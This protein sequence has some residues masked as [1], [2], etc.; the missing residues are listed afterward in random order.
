MT[1]SVMK[2]QSAFSCQISEKAL[3][4]MKSISKSRKVEVVFLTS[5]PINLSVYLKKISI[6]W[7]PGKQSTS[8]QAS[9][10]DTDH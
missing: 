5:K 9:L 4:E 6:D 8:V 2:A 3:Q 10:P 1:V 7:K